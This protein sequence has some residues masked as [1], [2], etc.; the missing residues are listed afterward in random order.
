M[1]DF[2]GLKLDHGGANLL[3]NFAT[4]S[5]MTTFENYTDRMEESK[6]YQSGA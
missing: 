2:G 4:T 5:V 1:D 3:E 6:A